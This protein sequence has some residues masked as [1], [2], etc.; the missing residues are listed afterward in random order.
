V[1]V[2]ALRFLLRYSAGT[3]AAIDRD[4][5]ARHPVCFVRGQIKGT[6]GNIL[7]FADTPQW[8][9]GGNAVALSLGGYN[10]CLITHGELDPGAPRFTNKCCPWS[11]NHSAADL[12]ELNGF[13]QRLEIALAE[14][15]VALALNNL[16]K[17]RT[18]NI[19]REYLQQYAVLH[20]AIDQNAPLL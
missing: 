14:A 1:W 11:S 19:G 16:E 5:G 13:K 6:V 2:Q 17:D 9:A 10:G 7:G 12:I 4:V 3:R 15:L 20:R 18:K 8:N